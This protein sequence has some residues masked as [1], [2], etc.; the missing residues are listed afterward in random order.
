MYLDK[1]LCQKS[2]KIYIFKLNIYIYNKNSRFFNAL[3]VR[4]LTIFSLSFDVK[5][6][7][8]VTIELNFL[9]CI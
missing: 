3:S 8:M 2:I 7:F 4:L 9:L 6:L 1:S 5:T